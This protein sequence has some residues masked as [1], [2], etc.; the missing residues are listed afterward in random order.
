MRWSA[1]VQL[2]PPHIK[3]SWPPTVDEGQV[4]PLFMSP[5]NQSYTGKEVVQVS[6][7]SPARLTAPCEHHH[8]P[9]M[10][11]KGHTETLM[12]FKKL[13]CCLG[14][15]PRESPSIRGTTRWHALR[16]IPTCPNPHGQ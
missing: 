13:C 16:V 2:K 14:D 15:Q 1:S 5:A 10:R 9:M 11:W 6:L 12:A 4:Q 3:P 7:V 8:A